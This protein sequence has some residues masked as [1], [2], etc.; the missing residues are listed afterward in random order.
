MCEGYRKSSSSGLLE[1][2]VDTVA[3]LTRAPMWSSSNSFPCQAAGKASIT[4]CRRDGSTVGY[5]SGKDERKVVQWSDADKL[6]RVAGYAGQSS[7]RGILI[8]SAIFTRWTLKRC[9]NPPPFTFHVRTVASASRSNESCRNATYIVYL[10]R[11]DYL[12]TASSLCAK[13][14]PDQTLRVP[15]PDLVMM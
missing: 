11:L 4:T 1:N 15:P 9:T 12:E 7:T 5:A 14:L 13:S 3:A 6:D 2:C 10:Q 8:P